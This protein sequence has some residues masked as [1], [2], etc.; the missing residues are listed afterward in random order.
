MDRLE[1]IRGGSNFLDHTNQNLEQTTIFCFHVFF[2]GRWLNFKFSILDTGIRHQI[3]HITHFGGKL[4][5]YS[6]NKYNLNDV[7]IAQLNQYFF[8]KDGPVQLHIFS[9]QGSTIYEAPVNTYV[10]QTICFVNYISSYNNY[11]HFNDVKILPD[12]DH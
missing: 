11:I 9:Q 7:Y 3:I 2:V 12:F 8:L 5:L 10:Q 6:R 1:L 4:C